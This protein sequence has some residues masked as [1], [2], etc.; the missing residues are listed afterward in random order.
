MS[1]YDTPHTQRGLDQADADAQ[2]YKINGKT[3]A[4]RRAAREEQERLH[5]IASALDDARLA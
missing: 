1:I 5:S 4:E 3:H 2:H